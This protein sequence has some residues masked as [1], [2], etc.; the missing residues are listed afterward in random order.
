MEIFRQLRVPK[1]P[2]YLVLL[3]IAI[4]FL[5]LL[6]LV[7]VQ[8]QR[9]V[10]VNRICLKSQRDPVYPRYSSWRKKR[11]EWTGAHQNSVS[12][13]LRSLLFY[14]LI[15]IYYYDNPAS[16]KNVGHHLHPSSDLLRFYLFWKKIT[17]G[18]FLRGF[19]W[20]HFYFLLF[21]LTFFPTFFFLCVFLIFIKR[22]RLE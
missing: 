10:V 19:F 5:H 8:G 3:V 2:I 17:L 12:E 4:N 14:K 18:K 16:S 13:R 20:E 6:H 22:G 7:P 15:Y 1:S 11:E 21:F 9:W